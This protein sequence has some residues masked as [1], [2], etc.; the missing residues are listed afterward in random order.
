MPAGSTLP[1]GLASNTTPQT[2]AV[3]AT[4]QRPVGRPWPTSI[5]ISPA[6]GGAA[7]ELGALRVAL[8]DGASFAGIREPLTVLEQMPADEPWDRV[9]LVHDAVHAAV[10]DAAASRRLSAAYAALQGELLFFVTRIRP[11]Y[12]VQ[13]MIDAHRLLADALT[14]GN[15]VAAEMALANDLAQ[16]RVALR[17]ALPAVG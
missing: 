17:T 12:T 15:P 7:L 8:A 10:V 4:T 1:A 11:L 6:S 9:A 14:G 16:G 5:A 3:V 13:T 2:A